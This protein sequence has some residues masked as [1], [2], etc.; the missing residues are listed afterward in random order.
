MTYGVRLATVAS[1]RPGVT[2]AAVRTVRCPPVVVAINSV[3]LR[4][5][6]AYSNCTEP[7]APLVAVE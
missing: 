4:R 1:A 6:H 7:S 5:Q 3:S 2:T